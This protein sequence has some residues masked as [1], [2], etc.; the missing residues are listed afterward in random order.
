MMCAPLILGNDV[1]KFIKED[2]TVDTENKVYQILTN[3]DMISVNQDS[4]GVQCKR[5]KLGFTDVLLKPLENS[6]AAILVFNKSGKTIT[7]RLD[8]RKISDNS[9]LN[10]PKK[11]S[12]KAYDVWEK[13]TLEDVAFIDAVV[14]SHGVKVYIVE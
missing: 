7:E 3:K 8:I 4:L 2:G 6:K 5:I 14:P 10:L 1:R 13:E 11:D 9:I 12:Y